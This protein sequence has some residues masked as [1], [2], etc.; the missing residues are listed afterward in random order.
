MK[1]VL[2]LWQ[3]ILN[4]C[5]R[6]RWFPFCWNS[7]KVA[8][9]IFLSMLSLGKVELKTYNNVLENCYFYNFLIKYNFSIA[10]APA[11]MSVCPLPFL[12]EIWKHGETCTMSAHCSRIY[13]LAKVMLDLDHL[14]SKIQCLHLT[15]LYSNCLIFLICYYLYFL[16]N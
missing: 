5:L 9:W 2:C 1:W 11:L 16:V 10:Y 4:P 14:D 6:K 3:L 12:E 15:K 7:L 8:R 13:W